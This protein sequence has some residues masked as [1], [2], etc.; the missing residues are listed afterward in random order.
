[1][2]TTVILC[3]VFIV[4]MVAADYTS[5][6]PD[7]F[8]PDVTVSSVSSATVLPTDLDNSEGE[9]SH[10]TVTVT[11][12]SSDDFTWNLVNWSSVSWLG[13][14]NPLRG[15]DCCNYGGGNYIMSPR[16]G[17]LY[18]INMSDGTKYDEFP[19][20]AA[21][22][23]PYGSYPLAS[24]N[25]NDWIKDVIY[26]STDLGATWST[27]TNPT[28]SNGRGLDCDY[29]AALVWETYINSAIYSF[30][31][32]ATSGTAYDVS[33]SI[34]DQMSGLATFEYNGD[35]WLAVTCYN[36]PN[37]YFYQ[38]RPGVLSYMGYG[39]L[40]YEPTFYKSYGITYFPDTDTFFWSFKNISNNCYL[41]EMSLTLTAL[42]QSS[43]GSI[44]AQF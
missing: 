10:S 37:S 26:H 19:L 34:P 23:Y 30:V 5:A 16:D 20:D 32:G 42:E 6:A 22:S 25:V 43:W 35:T 11:E 12:P 33:G 24:V 18:M 8:I 44:K 28:G 31:H 29:S 17:F 4:G 1:M 41:I 9:Y 38:V 39:V 36:S 13:A 40:P 14:G 27:V 7:G 21:N 3:I 15:L 2:K